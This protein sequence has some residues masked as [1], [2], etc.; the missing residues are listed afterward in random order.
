MELFKNEFALPE[1]TAAD[2]VGYDLPVVSD[3]EKKRVWPD[4][5]AAG[6][7]RIPV[8]LATNCRI[9]LLDKRFNC[10]LDFREVF[11]D[12]RAMVF[13]LLMAEYYRRM[14][15]NHFCDAPTAMPD[16]WN[17]A[18]HFQNVCEAWFFGADV[19]YRDNQVPDTEP[20]LNDENKNAIF[21][22]DISDP[23]SREPYCRVIKF[24]DEMT[25]Y[26]A[27]KT[28]LGRPIKIVAPAFQGSDGQMTVAMNLR[29]QNILMDMYDDPDYVNRLFDFIT[30]AAINRSLAFKKKYNLPDPEQVWFADDSIALL[31]VKQYEE[32]VL[33]HHKKLFD[34]MAKPGMTRF[35]HLCG[36][37]THHFPMLRE[38]LG[39][40][41]F[42]T[43]FPVDFAWLRRELGEDVMISGGVEVTLLASGTP[44][45]V[46]DRAKAILQSGIKRG[47]KFIMREAN[48]L[49]PD[50]PW[51]NLAAMYKATLDYGDIK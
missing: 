36:D 48:N 14:R 7:G 29:G 9:A 13:A 10:G 19:H 44:Q 38:R 20:W 2:I 1:L 17:V 32:F 28:F 23:L 25:Q 27:D 51:A 43:G 37:A 45:Q 30:Q 22:I 16:V 26:V 50:I 46:Y 6:V 49:P 33:K 24:Y 15:Y 18:V 35:I 42:D 12:P 39:V 31:G 3:A 4:F 47:G 21:D 41:G 11:E 8:M 34:A 5:T 40:T